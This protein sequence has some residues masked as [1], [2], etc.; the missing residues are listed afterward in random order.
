L[1]DTHY[2]KLKEVKLFCGAGN[3]NV[4]KEAFLKIKLGVE[5][6]MMISL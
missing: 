2:E 3:P 4:E 1:F 5:T 6:G